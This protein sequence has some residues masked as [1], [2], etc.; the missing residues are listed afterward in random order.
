MK[1][2]NHTATK[3][4]SN[5]RRDY[6]RASL[7]HTDLLSN[8]LDMIALWVEHASELP[9][10]TAMVL[11]T[12]ANQQPSSRVV[13]LKEITPSGLVWFTNYNSQKGGELAA[14][15][16]ASLLFFWAPLERQIRIEGRVEKVDQAQSDAYF[17]ERPIASQLSAWAS[18][19]SHRIESRE[20]LEQSLVEVETRFDNQTIPRPPHWGGY[21]LVPERIEFWQGRPNR[22]H[23]RLV[24]QKT[25]TE[26]WQIYRVA[27]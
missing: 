8:P 14:N 18:P 1:N 7:E 10:A 22:L 13:L 17:H 6:Q 26:A 23:D 3:N 21:C 19:Q 9:D 11:S 16:A 12:C 25:E 24:Y 27:P 2:M 4:W 20:Q 5:H 15:P